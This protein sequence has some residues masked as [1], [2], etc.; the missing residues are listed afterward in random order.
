MTEQGLRTPVHASDD[1]YELHERLM[2][3]AERLI[4]QADAQNLGR[5]PLLLW[6]SRIEAID[7][8]ARINESCHRYRSLRGSSLGQR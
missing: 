4:H 7:E 8:D 6:E 2:G 3:D 1:G 5:N